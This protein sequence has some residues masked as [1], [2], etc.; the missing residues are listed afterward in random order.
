MQRRLDERVR[1]KVYKRVIL[2]QSKRKN[3]NTGTGTQKFVSVKLR[4]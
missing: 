1:N 3:G 4:P 2:T